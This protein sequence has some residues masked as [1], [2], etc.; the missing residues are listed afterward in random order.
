MNLALDRDTLRRAA[1]PGF[2]RV[3][4]YPLIRELAKVGIDAP[5][6]ERDAQ[7]D[8]G[9]A[10]VDRCHVHRDGADIDST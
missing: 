6:M 2:R 8:W 9:N 5:T 3:A 1:A 4:R 10:G 7:C